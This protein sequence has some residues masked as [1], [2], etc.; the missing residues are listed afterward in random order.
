MKNVQYQNIIILTTME[1]TLEI[2]AWDMAGSSVVRSR[3]R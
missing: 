2:I 1:I 3:G